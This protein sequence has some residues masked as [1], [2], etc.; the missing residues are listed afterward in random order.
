[1]MFKRWKRQFQIETL[2][3]QQLIGRPE[4]QYE[5]E[6]CILKVEVAYKSCE[7][8]GQDPSVW[9]VVIMLRCSVSPHILFCVDGWI[10]NFSMTSHACLLTQLD[11]V[12][13]CPSEVTVP[14]LPLHKS[15]VFL[16]I[17]RLYSTIDR[18]LWVLYLCCCVCQLKMGSYRIMNHYEPIQ[19]CFM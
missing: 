9:T 14:Q 17:Q 15:P 11:G 7:T 6:T 13:P 16:T 4:I 12:T 10:G 5:D 19:S 18:Y 8:F 3:V 1:M 2:Y